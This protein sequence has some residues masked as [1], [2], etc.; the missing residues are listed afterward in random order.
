M[1][2]DTWTIYEYS[3]LVIAAFLIGIVIVKIKK[4]SLDKDMNMTPGDYKLV[5]L[6]AFIVFTIFRWRYFVYDSSEFMFVLP[7]LTV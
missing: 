4:S 2:K 5:V 6:I 1:K 3:F 7:F